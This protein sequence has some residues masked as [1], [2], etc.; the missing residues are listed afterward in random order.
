MNPIFPDHNV[1]FRLF[2]DDDLP[3]LPPMRWL[4][5][6]VLPESGLAAIYEI[7]RAHV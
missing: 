3:Q 5:K 7:G 1:R 6:G 2:S 4:V